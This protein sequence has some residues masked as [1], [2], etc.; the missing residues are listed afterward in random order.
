MPSP[1]LMGSILARQTTQGE[2]RVVG[3]ALPLYDPPTR[4]AEEFAM[5]DNISRRAAHRRLR[6]RRRARVLQ[7]LDQPGPRPRALPRG[8][9]H[10]HQGLDR[11]RA[12]RV[13]RQA[14]PAALHEHVAAAD[15]AAAPRG[16]DPGRGLAGDDGVRRRA[17]LRLHGHPVLPHRAC[18]TASSACSARPASG[19][20]TRYE[21]RAGGL[22]GAHLRG[23]DRRAGPGRVRAALLVL[24]PAS[25]CPASRSARPATRRCGRWRTC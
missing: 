22:A 21:P 16:L 5:I 2:D 17:P 8:P 10:H 7:L 25:C 11:A 14:L 12:V 23:R 9:R 19:R 20:A 18:S 13:H 6:R 1:N 15:P 3:N 24:R 4:V